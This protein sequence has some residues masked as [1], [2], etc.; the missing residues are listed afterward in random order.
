MPDLPHNSIEV[1]GEK[2]GCELNDGYEAGASLTAAAARMQAGRRWRCG[3]R[4]L[5]ATSDGGSRHEDEKAEYRT[6]G[7][8]PVVL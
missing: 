8:N 7:A 5:K 2:G 3:R 6:L 4:R 1:I